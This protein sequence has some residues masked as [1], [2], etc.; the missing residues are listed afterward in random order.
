MRI[1]DGQLGTAMFSLAFNYWYTDG[2]GEI[3]ID[4]K[5]FIDLGPLWIGLIPDRVRSLRII[6]TKQLIFIQIWILSKIVGDI[7]WQFGKKVWAAA[8][9]A[10][11]RDWSKAKRNLGVLER[12]YTYSNIGRSKR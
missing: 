6:L 1:R 8:W 10:V 4:L 2:F 5:E 3:E 11:V 9:E 7:R 12:E